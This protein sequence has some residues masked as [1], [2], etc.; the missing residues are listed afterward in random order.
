MLQENAQYL[1]LGALPSEGCSKPFDFPQL[2]PFVCR[3][4]PAAT[5]HA[6]PDFVGYCFNLAELATV[7]PSFDECDPQGWTNSIYR[8]YFYE[9][10]WM[11]AFYPH[12]GGDQLCTTLCGALHLSQ[13]AVLLSW[14]LLH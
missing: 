11:F 8:W 9:L 3:C 7:Y 4:Q 13:T 14:V 5:F 1:F 10:A 6:V 12:T 2:F